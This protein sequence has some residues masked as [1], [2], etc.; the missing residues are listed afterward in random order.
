MSDSIS[1][2]S[3]DEQGLILSGDSAIRDPIFGLK[4]LESLKIAEKGAIAA[5]VDE[6]EYIIQ[7]FDAPIVAQLISLEH[8]VWTIQT[9]YH[10]KTTFDLHSLTLDEWDRFHGFTAEGIPFV[11][12]A[13]AQSQF[14][15]FLDE[16][17]DDSICFQGE[18]IEIEDWLPDTEE[19]SESEFWSQC[20]QNKDTGWNLNQPAPALVDM[21]PRL[22]LPKSKVL[23][24]GSGHGHDAAHFAEQGHLVT[25]VDFSAEA[26]TAAKKLYGH[27]SNLQ[28][29]EKD[30]FELE[31]SYHNSFDIIFE[32]ACYCA[33][34]PARR[35]ELT[36]LWKKLLRENGQIIAVLFATEKRIGPPFGGSEWEI[37][38]RLKKS[39]N[40]LFWGR[41][42]TSLP[43]RMGRE[44]FIFAQK[45]KA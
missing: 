20:Y 33:V 29:V 4:V 36:K 5:T 22:K 1:F 7:A 21:L 19:P 9:H 14:F 30:I 3:I 23:V 34:N 8:S 32:Q 38:Q 10:F 37:R 27:Y 44:L 45:L 28:F 40:F 17:T 25:A 11:M 35:T 41:W 43:N 26:I 15:D 24:L 42:Q 31:S 6:Q 18:W 12:T 2:L 39:F 13:Q 16:Y